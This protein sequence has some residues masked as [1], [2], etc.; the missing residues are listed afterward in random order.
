MHEAAKFESPI[1]AHVRPNACT[2]AR[3]VFAAPLARF[4]PKA[5]FGLKQLDQYLSSE[6]AVQ[7]A[8]EFGAGGAYSSWAGSMGKNLDHEFY[9]ADAIT[10]EDVAVLK[11]PELW[12]PASRPKPRRVLILGSSLQLGY[13]VLHRLQGHDD[14]TI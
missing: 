4:L 1:R 2:L 9:R 10:Y 8:S 11:W 5:H 14:E 7:R 13:Q 12:L 6:A 3:L